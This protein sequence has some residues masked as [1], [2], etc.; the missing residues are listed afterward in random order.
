MVSDEVHLELFI[1]FLLI[2]ESFVQIVL[3]SRVSSIEIFIYFFVCRKV[4][5]P[6]SLKA[7]FFQTNVLPQGEEVHFWL[8][9]GV[10]NQLPL[11][12]SQSWSARKVQVDLFDNVMPIYKNF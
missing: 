3:S 12:K 4:H 1:L 10:K 11:T 5:L 9:L 7:A 8:V 2:S 6:S